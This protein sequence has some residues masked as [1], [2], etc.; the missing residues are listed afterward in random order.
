MTFFTEPAFVT[1]FT[2]HSLQNRSISTCPT[3]RQPQ[4]GRREGNTLISAV[5]SDQTAKTQTWGSS[6]TTTYDVT[7][8][9]KNRTS[10]IQVEEDSN[11]RTALLS[12]GVDVYTFGGKLRNCGGGGQC[13]TCLVAI[14]DGFYRTNPRGYKEEFMLKSKPDNWRLACRT[15]V[16]GDLTV[17]TKPQA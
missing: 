15:V 14:E 5:L 2:G 17:Q 1:S 8:I 16:N 9:Q 13:G 11:L 10:V 12:N 3:T 7:V 6:P 4:S